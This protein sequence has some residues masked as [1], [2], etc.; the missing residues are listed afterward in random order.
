MRHVFFALSLL[1]GLM[2][3]AVKSEKFKLD[4]LRLDVGKAG[5]FK[6]SFH[7]IPSGHEQV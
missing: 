2:L 5:Q 3:E 1:L 4:A 6:L 7:T